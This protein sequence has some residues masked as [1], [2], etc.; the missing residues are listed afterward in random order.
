MVKNKFT[1]ILL[2]FLCLNS[3]LLAKKKAPDNTWYTD[4]NG[5]GKND[6]IEA[7]VF[8]NQVIA[9]KFYVNGQFCDL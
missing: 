3:V 2:L 7:V 5:D 6:T 1:Y 8:A 9:Y 4:V